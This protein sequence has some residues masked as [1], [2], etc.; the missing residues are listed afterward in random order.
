M[1]DLLA[2][3]EVVSWAQS[4]CG[5]GGS[6]CRIFERLCSQRSR[7]APVCGTEFS[8]PR[9]FGRRAVFRYWERTLLMIQNLRPCEK[10]EG[11][12][13]PRLRKPAP[14]SNF[15]HMKTRAPER[16]KSRRGGKA[17]RTV[18]TNGRRQTQR[19]TE[20]RAMAANRG[21]RTTDHEQI[22]NWA[23]ARGDSPAIVTRTRSGKG[24]DGGVLRIDFPGFSGEGSLEHVSWE[25]WFRV[26]DERNLE[27]LYQQKTASGKPSRFNKLVCP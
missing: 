23:E 17:S 24:N 6:G 8:L 27:F 22:R 12:R 1:F 19:S 13:T 5:S 15:V 10:P 26:F 21:K 3:C 14:L 4:P 11:G 9:P 16:A 7:L 25:E 18:K 2:P 20:R